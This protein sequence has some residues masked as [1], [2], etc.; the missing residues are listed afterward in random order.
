MLQM[1]LLQQPLQAQVLLGHSERSG[2]GTSQG[3]ATHLELRSINFYQTF[4]FIQV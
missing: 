4:Y 2:S 1:H 3:V